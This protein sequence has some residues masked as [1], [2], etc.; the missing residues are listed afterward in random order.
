MLGATMIAMATS[1][2]VPA[3]AYEPVLHEFIPPDDGEDLSLATTTAEGDLPAAI[4]TRSGVVRAPETQRAPSSMESAYREPL[5]PNAPSAY[6]PDRDTRRPSMVRYD[7]PFSPSI[8]PYKRLRAYD[9]VGPDYTLRVH[10]PSLT[11]LPT[12]GAARVGEEEF[13]ADL[14]VDFAAASTVLIPSVGPGARIL[15][16]HS[17]PS[18]PIEVLRDGAD[19]WY[20]KAPASQ[21]GRVH[22]VMQVAIARAAFGG[23]LT[24]APW[25]ALAAPAPLPAAAA[26]AFG[27]VRDELGLSRDISPAENVHKL[28]AY[29]RSFAPSE[30]PPKATD[31]IYLDLT[32]AKKG[33]CRHR[34]FGFLVTALGL[35]IPTRMVINEAHAWV[36]VQ[37]DRVW[38]RIDLGGAAGAIE[39]GAS[40]EARPSYDPPPDAFGWPP[41][42]E[43]GS[44]HEVALR[45]RQNASSSAPFSSAATSSVEGTSEQGLG[46]RSTDRVDPSS[47]ASNDE[48]AHARVVIRGADAQVHRGAPVHLVGT[49]ESEGAGCGQVRV[50]VMLR[51]AST[52]TSIGSLVTNPEGAFDGNLFLP[53]SFPVGDY[54]VVASTPGDARCGPGG[55]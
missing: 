40:S 2:A 29:F 46:A 28:V 36:E 16:E 13:Y 31:D 30:E 3:D 18:V 47:R 44:G 11:R 50:D 53:L 26:R 21:R 4:D 52:S 22:L 48:R 23:E 38:Q 24:M 15:A 51:G 39:E 37:A 7:D 45:G 27:K 9:A 42:A 43:S 33:V 25:S 34:A 5:L 32:L 54:E 1:W 6:R 55:S 17:T 12:G 35:G 10:D 8:A 20:A 49:V 14:T 19:N 41:S